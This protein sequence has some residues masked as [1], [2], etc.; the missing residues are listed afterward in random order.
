MSVYVHAFK[1]AGGRHF[2][3]TG[4]HKS[5]TLLFQTNSKELQNTTMHCIHQWQFYSFCC[6][7]KIRQW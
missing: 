6:Q 2:D 5:S 4:R 1:T 7:E 3:L